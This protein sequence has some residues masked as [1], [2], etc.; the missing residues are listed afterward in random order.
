MK[1]RASFFWFLFMGSS[2]LSTRGGEKRRGRPGGG[3]IEEE[4]P[5]DKSKRK[6]RWTNEKN[7][8]RF[9]I[10]QNSEVVDS[11]SGVGFCL[12]CCCFFVWIMSSLLNLSL[13]VGSRRLW[14][15][16][17]GLDVLDFLMCEA[18]RKK[19][20]RTAIYEDAAVVLGWSGEVVEQ[21]EQ[22]SKALRSRAEQR[23]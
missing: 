14:T 18:V 10:L 6:T 4:D 17:L 22:S 1:N 15:P 13:F 11:E 16:N 20:M 3:Q 21:G 2:G 19:E 7:E 8:A 23:S 9:F 12:L 5:V